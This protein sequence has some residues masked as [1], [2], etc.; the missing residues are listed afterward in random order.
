M[1]LTRLTALLFVTT[2]LA[3]ADP[4][5]RTD[6]VG[7]PLPPGAVARI[8]TVRFL[9]RP[10]LHQVFFTADGSTVIG[11][12]GSDVLD[13]WEAETGKPVGELRDP[14]LV[15][16]RADLSPDG[17]YLALWGH[18]RRGKPA[19]DT[20]LRLYD[21][22]TR[23][24][25]WTSVIS[26]VYIPGYHR[27]RFSLD[28]TRLLTGSALD[29][30]V[31]DAATGRELV[32]HNV[33]TT[34]GGFTLSPDGKTAAITSDRGIF[35]WDWQAG[36]PRR[37]DVGN[38]RYLNR[39]YFATDGKIAYTHSDDGP[40][41]VH[42]YDVATGKFLGKADESHT[43]WRAVSPDGK[44]LAVAVYDRKTREGSV[45]LWEVGTGKEVGR[46]Q[47]GSF[48][49]SDGRWSKDGTKLAGATAFR[50][51]VWDVKTGRA[52]GPD[53][54]RH[55]ARLSG[56]VFHS[57]GRIFTGSDDGTVRAWDSA[58]GKEL[59]RL[60]FDRAPWGVAVSP[61]GGLLARSDE[62]S[63]I[64]LRDAGTGRE[65]FHLVW[66]TRQTGGVYLVKFTNDE[67]TLLTY[68]SDY[69]LRAWDTLT[70][71]LKRESKIRPPGLGP[72]GDD[73]DEDS[74]RG[75]SSLSN[76]TI[77]LTPD[78][79][80]LVLASGR[81]VTAFAADTGKERFRLQAD[82]AYVKNL[83]LSPDGRR[84][85][86]IESGPS[87]GPAAGAPAR[88]PPTLVT[89]WNMTE[90]T[91]L[92]RTELPATVGFN[93]LAFSPDGRQLVTGSSQD[94]TLHFLEADTG[95]TVGT[96]DLP[97]PP[98]L[99]IAFGDHRR[100]AVSFWDS[101]VLVYDVP[102]ALRPAKK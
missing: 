90:A 54:P 60:Q 15:N 21:L 102:A 57:D 12:G 45:I 43:H 50:A 87:V 98:G 32:R 97:R 80:T 71:K 101:T 55:A 75:L 7:D 40:L 14:D 47:S 9:P 27:V 99:R 28:G 31:W 22:A 2:P 78:G 25:L 8:G 61:D 36:P 3:A 42:A 1:R 93:V 79:S 92:S 73:E 68:G 76:R 82:A 4:P 83:V 24:P 88:L 39:L 35:F 11:H 37:A 81:D 66:S 74:V 23:K 95:K 38:R 16:F 69:H 67:Q 26:D 5:A 62:P 34:Y 30:R 59:S 46:L 53:V 91:R 84:L 17:K 49:L 58:S 85:A 20:A 18:D 48:L 51:W 72:E 64:Q 13:F 41:T 33:P 94:T 29:V 63:S 52:F 100:L 77:D 19:R 86:A 89:V 96:I 70:G 44:R 10:E 65:L 56:L 6:L